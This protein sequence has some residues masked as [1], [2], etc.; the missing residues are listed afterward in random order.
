MNE[1]LTSDMSEVVMNTSKS[2]G[3][4]VKLSIIMMLAA[5]LTVLILSGIYYILVVTLRGEIKLS[6][7]F[8][9]I[10]QPILLV[11]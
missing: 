9:F 7:C 4:A 5:L 2:F 8:Q 3:S 1:Q 6:I 10:L 11:S